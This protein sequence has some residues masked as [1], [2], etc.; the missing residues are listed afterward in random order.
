MMIEVKRHDVKA[1]YGKRTGKLLMPAHYE[2]RYYHKGM[3]IAWYN[4]L[5]D[6]L[7]LKTDLIG[8]DFKMPCYERA[9]TSKYKEVY[10]YLFDMLGTDKACKLSEYTNM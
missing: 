10:R 2:C 6:T 7:Y 9:L 8:H 1:F 4:S 3:E 5:S